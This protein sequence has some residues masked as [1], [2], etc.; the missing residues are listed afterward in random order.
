MRVKVLTNCRSSS[1]VTTFHSGIAASH[2]G[3]CVDLL[4]GWP[5]LR[6]MCID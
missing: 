5:D 3:N 2:K 6:S 1:G 4:A